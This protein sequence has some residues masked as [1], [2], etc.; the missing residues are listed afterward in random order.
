MADLIEDIF[1][2]AS[3][4][5]EQ[6]EG[7]VPFDQ[8]VISLVQ[9]NFSVIFPSRLRFLQT[10]RRV[11]EV[12]RSLDEGAGASRLEEN[13]VERGPLHP[14]FILN[15]FRKTLR[16]KVSNLMNLNPRPLIVPVDPDPRSVKRAEKTRLELTRIFHEI[17]LDR[18]WV[19][20]W[21]H[22]VM[23]GNVWVR[24]YLEGQRRQ[25][26]PQS[27]CMRC[28][29]V[30]DLLVGEGSCPSCG[31]DS[32]FV[33]KGEGASSG[34]V[35]VDIASVFE[36]VT[37]WYVKNFEEVASFGWIARFRLLP[38]PY[39]KRLYP[40][41]PIEHGMGGWRSWGSEGYD[42][43]AYLRTL[44]PDVYAEDI[45][46]TGR[47]AWEDVALLVE[48]WL[49]PPHVDEYRDELGIPPDY[50]CHIVFNGSRVLEL[51]PAKIEDEWVLFSY[52]EVPESLI[53]NSEAV[54]LLRLQDVLNELY[55]LFIVSAFFRG[56]GMVFA[57][58]AV[59]D[60]NRVSASPDVIHPTK[61]LPPGV[62]IAN[63]LHTVTAQ[64]IDGSLW[65]LYTSVLGMFHDLGLI[66]PTTDVRDVTGSPTAYAAAALRQQMVQSMRPLVVSFFESFRKLCGILLSLSYESWPEDEVRF[67]HVPGGC[68]E[69]IH[70]EDVLAP[71]QFTIIMRP[72]IIAP[73]GGY[74]THEVV[75]D[76]LKNKVITLDD[77]KNVVRVASLFQLEEFHEDVINEYG[78]VEEAIRKAIAH[79]LDEI[80]FD[81]ALDMHE[82]WISV[83]STF[84]RSERGQRLRIEDE[85][86]YNA[87]RSCLEAHVAAANQDLMGAAM[88]HTRALVWDSLARAAEEI[89]ED[90]LKSPSFFQALRMMIFSRPKFRSEEVTS[91]DIS[92]NTAGNTQSGPSR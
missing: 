1:V 46:A 84:L 49:S 78:R 71:G 69:A 55:S 14:R 73:G 22:L 70:K 18:L 60:I 5:N 56:V 47:R 38:V 67:A 43:V 6:R 29:F 66:Y 31:E 76:A 9:K 45:V 30:V 37:P 51:R 8:Y 59:I 88:A 13:K 57:N 58:P 10:C 75:A 54:D 27:M 85:R 39:V 36:I 12:Y 65:N 7:R 90:A 53:A 87:L 35:A 21:E 20:L 62:P 77:P 42:I 40:G 86:A 82:V 26:T 81:A 61:N 63:S 83:L 89:G 16:V 17:N 44:Q 32:V 79:E 11:V 34:R 91:Y 33:E 4:K 48:I 28:G 50:G 92:G 3:E 25:K 74:D 2:R 64:G 72:N 80:P 24:P 41:V 68:A 52:D 15:Q 23:F 19:R